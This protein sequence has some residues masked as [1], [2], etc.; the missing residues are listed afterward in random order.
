MRVASSDKGPADSPIAL[1]RRGGSAKRAGHNANRP[2]VP[3]HPLSRFSGR[4]SAIIFPDVAVDFIKQI[5]DAAGVTLN[6]VMLGVTAGLLRRYSVARGDAV[7]GPAASGAVFGNAAREV[8]CQT[9]V[10]LP[11]AFPRQGRN[12]RNK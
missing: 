10:L 6:D 4:R 7:F 11:L 3:T 5:K 8:K 12:L 2:G 1:L 9:R